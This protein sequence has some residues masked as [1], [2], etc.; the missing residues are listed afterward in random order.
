MADTRARITQTGKAVNLAQ[1]AAEAGGPLA[2]SSTE[3]VSVDGTLTVQVLQAAYDAHV[4]DPNYG[5]PAEDTAATG[6]RAK[7]QAVFNGTDTFTAAQLQRL[8]AALVLRA[9]R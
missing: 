4:A 2:A 8:V 3:I 9:T 6:L 1:L 5:L 7:A